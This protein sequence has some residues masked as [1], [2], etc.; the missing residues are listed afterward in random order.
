MTTDEAGKERLQKILARAG[1]GSRRACE[2]LIVEGRV[3]VNDQTVSVLGVRA[4]PFRDVIAV[5]TERVHLPKPAYWM[6]NKQEG[7]SFND[8]EAEH[9][10]QDLV[11][12][13]HGRLFTA[14][15]LDRQA[16]GLML[17]TN[18][19]RVANILTH[20]RYRVPKV[21]R[22]TV[23]G[24]VEIAAVR[25]IERALYYAM[26]SGHFQP[27]IIGKRSGGQTQLEV[28]VYEGLPQAV[29]DICLKFG[30]GVRQVERI[31][32]GC[33]EMDAMVGGALR[34]LRGDEIRELLQ[35]ADEAE[36]GRLNYE[37]DLVNPA[38]FK[39]DDEETGF[40]RKKTGT[41][42]TSTEG[43][44]KTS[45]RVKTQG[46]ARGKPWGESRGPKRDGPRDDRKGPPRG[47]RKDSRGP[48]SD[49]PRGERSERPRG[50]RSDSRS[51]SRG[52]EGPRSSGPRRDRSD[53]PRG[54]SDRPRGPRS[55]GPRSS[56]PRRDRSDSPRGG[57]DRP[58]GPR[59]EGPR[60]SGP[61][62]DRSDGPRGGSDRPRGPRSDGPRSSGP[63]RDR[64]DSPRGGSDRPRGPR[65]DGPRSSAP[66][67]ERSEGPRG[68]SDRPRGP[69]SD[70][71]RRPRSDS[72]RGER[73]ERPRGPRS[74]SPRGGSDRPR[75]DKR[76][77]GPR[78]GRPSGPGDKR[79]GP[80]SDRPKGPH[81]K[82]PGGPSRRPDRD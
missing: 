78:T 12:G 8:S 15:R 72:P 66:R 60:S 41:R 14:G 56:G 19:G 35:Y 44:K 70:S 54:G 13:E 7:T 53:S 5:D 38:R 25:N 33:L 61:R 10:L 32:L 27:I 39:R 67:R 6:L 64:S 4:D 26:N 82:R 20:P 76:R 77:S 75:D 31:R 21:Y 48:R 71:P 50:P 74:D 63:R 65:G 57:G 47:D 23:R 80:R 24:A 58:R 52:S 55:E 40:R 43:Q 17:I 79:D 42:G 49:S 11:K 18:D 73:S 34:K 3:T 68:G 30:H 59:S 28:V 1:Y 2:E 81:G 37:K 46:G 29:R 36:A 9:A 62:R 69:R 16:R 45:A 22:L 51:D